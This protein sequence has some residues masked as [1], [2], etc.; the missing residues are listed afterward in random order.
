MRFLF[1]ALLFLSNVVIAK[2]FW[3]LYDGNGTF[4]QPHTGAITTVAN[5]A[6]V[7]CD[8]YNA[9]GNIPWLNKGGD[10]KDK[11][12]TK[13]G[14]V[15]F[16]EAFVADVILASGPPKPLEIDATPLIGAKGAFLRLSRATHVRIGL[17]E[18]PDY[19][20]ILESTLADGTV[21]KTLITADNSLQFVG[22]NK[23]SVNNSQKSPT[24]SINPSIVMGFDWPEGAVSAKLKL[25]VFESSS[26]SSFLELYEMI[27]PKIETSQDHA[28]PVNPNARIIWQQD[29][30]GDCPKWWEGLGYTTKPDAQWTVDPCPGERFGWGSFPGQ[31]GIYRANGVGKI[32]AQG[33]T[34]LYIDREK[35]WNN[36]NGFGVM[37]HDSKLAYGVD[38]RN[39]KLSAINGGEL[40]KAWFRV[41]V[42]FNHGFDTFINGD[43]GK[44]PG[45]KNL[46]DYCSGS[47]VK[48][49]G[50]CGW[51]LR[52]GFRTGADSDNPMF[53]YTRIDTY[54][55][56]AFQR[57]YTGSSW[58]GDYRAMIKNGEWACYEQ[59]VTVNTP[60][61]A[62]GI[63]Q[64][65]VNGVLVL[66]KRDVYLRGKNPA[67]LTGNPNHGYGDWWE[68]GTAYPSEPIG[69]PRIFDPVTNK[70]F[71]HR[72]GPNLNTEL[73]IDGL[74]WVQ[75]GGGG[76]PIGKPG[77]SMVFD[78]F[79]VSEDRIG[80]PTANEV[81][82]VEICGNGID[83]NNNGETDEGCPP[84]PK[85]EICGNNIDDDGDELVDE[86]CQL[87]IC[88]NNIDDDN[89][90]VKDEDCPP[91]VEVCGNNLDDNHNGSTDEGCPT[92]LELA[93]QALDEAMKRLAEER[94]AHNLTSVALGAKSLQVSE[95]ELNL[96]ALHG[97]LAGV[98]GELATQA[99]VLAGVQAA[100]AVVQG[101]LETTET[102]LAAATVQVEEVSFALQNKEN[103]LAKCNEELLSTTK[104]HNELMSAKSKVDELLDN[105]NVNVDV[106]RNG[107]NDLKLLSD[108]G[109]K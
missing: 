64:L 106:L 45:F 61:V 82:P 16:A 21:V 22:F 3:D 96:S 52:N 39:V 6:G 80:C 32:L 71:F 40:R 48:A 93:K 89:D 11:N 107:I 75:H 67:E 90:G 44:L 29:F 98:Q 86:E 15:P 87:E 101:N 54:A 63:N 33:T 84:D 88:G 4:Q 23:C 25:W 14:N 24:G 92:E 99:G 103:E 72:G 46:I 108:E 20:P 8:Y 83:D 35:G 50:Y 18:N 94:E 59:H 17:R 65:Y 34:N 70:T 13:Q 28:V 51:T 12:G 109:L 47:G 1:L 77:V 43:G 2:D 7:S 56:H 91:L 100:L 81:P 105:C 95:L 102:K 58:A 74:Y 26:G 79:V 31:G 62:D 60:G 53:G 104:A 10:W 42:K 55:Y 37:H 36:T 78:E 69:A 76:Q 5:Q 85:P 9:M 19:F 41:M 49:N 57:D 68:A 73:A 97:E 27:V 66:D 30:N 38:M